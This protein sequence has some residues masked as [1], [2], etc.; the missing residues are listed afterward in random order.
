[1]AEITLED[2]RTF[3]VWEFRID[4]EEEGHRDECTVGPYLVTGPLDATDRMFVVRAV[5]ILADGTRMRGYFTPPRRDDAGIGTLQPIIVTDR[6][7][8]RLWCGTAAPDSK[9]LAHSYELLG[10]DAKH[11]F[12]VQFESEVELVGGPI[13]GGVLGFLVL[14]DFQTRKARTVT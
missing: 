12:P 9:R 4:Q 1:M 2:L 6:G 8:V 7:Q 10:R 5:F 11:V 13:K 14:E 3:P